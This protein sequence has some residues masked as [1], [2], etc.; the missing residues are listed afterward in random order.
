MLPQM[1]G[2]LPQAVLGQR[3]LGKAICIS[4]L[5]KNLFTTFVHF[6]IIFL[7]LNFKSALYILDTGPLTDI[8]FANIFSH[9]V[10]HPLFLF[11]L[12]FCLKY[13]SFSLE[14]WK[15]VVKI[16]IFTYS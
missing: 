3:F 8:Q 9:L 15:E 6:K 12:S 2:C 16:L 13:F 14:I 1:G 4:Y 10:G 7:L 11:K 5:E